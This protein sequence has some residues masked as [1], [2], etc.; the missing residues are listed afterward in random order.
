MIEMPAPSGWILAAAEAPGLSP[1]EDTLD[2]A[3]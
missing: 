2:T 1:I 3:T